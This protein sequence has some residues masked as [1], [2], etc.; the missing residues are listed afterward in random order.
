M[1]A[2]LTGGTKGSA[3]LNAATDP[4]VDRWRALDEEERELLHCGA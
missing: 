3:A 2:I 1:A 4:A